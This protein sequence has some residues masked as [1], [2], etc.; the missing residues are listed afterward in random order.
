[1][2]ADRDAAVEGDARRFVELRRLICNECRVR[3]ESV[4]ADKTTSN[5]KCAMSAK[6]ALI[7]PFAALAAFAFPR[8]QPFF[9][10]THHQHLF[11]AV[12][13]RNH[14]STIIVVRGW[15]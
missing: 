11:N 8:R 13:A 9:S 10:C 6:K 2:P 15:A 4:P 7:R 14:R 5:A 1:M 12:G 3:D